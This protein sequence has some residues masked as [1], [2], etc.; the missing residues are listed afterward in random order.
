MGFFFWMADQKQRV[1]IPAA[2]F[3]YVWDHASGLECFA[4]STAC[5]SLR[6]EKMSDPV[7][8]S[9]IPYWQ[10]WKDENGISHQRRAFRPPNKL[11]TV[12]PGSATVW[13]CITASVP[14]KVFLFDHSS[15]SRGRL[16]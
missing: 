12:S 1:Q 15:R 8:G 10:V 6:S 3:S 13:Q 11:S 5:Y 9:A 4:Q 2:R 16:A 14:T 7:T